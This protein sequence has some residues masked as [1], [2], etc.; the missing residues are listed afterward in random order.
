M[1]A[2][3]EAWRRPPRLAR[4]AT[5]ISIETCPHYLFFTEDDVERLGAVAKCAP[6][7]RDTIEQ[8]CSVGATA[9]GSGRHR[10]LRIIRPRP[11]NEVGAISHELGRHR[12]SAV[13]SCRAAGSRLPLSPATA[14]TNRIAH[15][16]Q[17][18]A[19]F[20]FQ[21]RANCSRHGRGP[22]ARG[23]LAIHPSA[24]RNI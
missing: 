24:P 9:R 4:E 19:D 2:R 1:S 17:P 15:R 13:D 20:G 8:R 22:G 18:R 21:I 16:G 6:P 3:A 14:G 10:R 11:V 7:L 23:S 5:D 12:R